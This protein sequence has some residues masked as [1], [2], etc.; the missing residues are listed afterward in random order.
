ML[1]AL[2]IGVLLAS[3]YLIAGQVFG[4]VTVEQPTT[5]ERLQ[6]YTF[7]ATSTVQT[8][9]A[10][11]ATATSTNIIAWFDSN[12]IKDNGYFVV[13]G[14]K[15][16]TLYFKRGDTVGTGN[17][18]STVYKIQTSPDGS[19][20]FDYPYL[21]K[22]TTTPTTAD[23]FF[24]GVA[25]ATIGAATTTDI[26]KMGNTGWFAIRCIVVETTDGEHSCSATAQF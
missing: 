10:T 18:G 24:A 2:V 17:T 11:T 26:Y 1:S 7:F 6:T 13:A 12:G 22:A 23:T 25:S 19:N 16:V 8:N 9:F 20:W 14:A 15:D 5:S 4:N 3:V 21:K